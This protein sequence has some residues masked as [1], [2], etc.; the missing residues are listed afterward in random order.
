MA[1]ADWQQISRAGGQGGPDIVSN[2]GRTLISLGCESVT[3]RVTSR[4]DTMYYVTV[5]R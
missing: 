5:C 4:V 1:A 2:S 3:G